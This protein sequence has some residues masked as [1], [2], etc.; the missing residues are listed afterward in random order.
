MTSSSGDGF[1]S[2]RLGRAGSSGP[3]GRAPGEKEKGEEVKGLFLLVAWL[4]AEMLPE[5]CVRDLAIQLTG[6]DVAGSWGPDP[7][8][9]V[10]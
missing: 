1:C 3:G 9:W 8:R 6:W 4:Q 7:Q 10:G 5:A 2:R